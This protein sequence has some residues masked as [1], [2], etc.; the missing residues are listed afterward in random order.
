MFLKDEDS[1]YNGMYNIKLKESRIDNM[2][3]KNYSKKAEVIPEFA[4]LAKQQAKEKLNQKEVK[5]GDKTYVIKKWEHTE[6]LSILPAFANLLYVPTAAMAAD[7]G[8]EE[9]GIYV[10]NPTSASDMVGILFHRL[11]EIEVVDFMK[12]MLNQVYVKGENTPIDIY[13]DV[14]NSVY[15][16]VLFVDVAFVIF[17]FGL[18]QAMYSSTMLMVAA[19]KVNQNLSSQ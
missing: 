4:H 1:L 9:E 15:F 5:V 13:K 14:V 12:D 7:K 18:C 19:Q 2:A 6:T 3:Q 16:L 10:E 17:L 8:A 11:A